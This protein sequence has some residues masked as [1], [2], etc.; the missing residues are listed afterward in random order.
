MFSHC[1]RRIARQAVLIGC[2][3]V[4]AGC[5][6][7]QVPRI[8]PT[9]ESFFIWPNQAP[10]AVVAAPA[11]G[12]PIVGAPTAGA[13]GMP[14]PGPIAPATGIGAP[15]GNLQAPPVY[16]DPTPLAASVTAPTAVAPVVAVPGAPVAAPLVATMRPVG[17]PGMATP[18]GT[19]APQGVRYLRVTPNGILAPI[20]SEVVLKAGVA[21]CDGTLLVNR[22]VEW[23]I[24]G[25]G[26]FSDLGARY[27]VG[28]VAWPWQTPRRIAANH[29]TSTTALS[30]STLFTGTPDPNDDV[31]IYRGEAWVTVTSPCEGTSLVTA[32]APSLENHNR[33]TVPIYWVD[34]Q[35][36]FPASATAELGRPH[37]LTTT[38]LRRSDNA[39]LAGWTVRYDVASGGALGYEGGK[40]V[41]T[42]TDAAGRAS[43]EVSPVDPGGGTTNVSVSIYRPAVGGPG[44]APPLG[45]GRGNA[46][47]TWGAGIPTVP[48]SPP[49]AISTPSPPP[50]VDPN[51]PGA[52]PPFPY[53]PSQPPR[54]NGSPGPI[55]PPP[56]LPNSSPTRPDGY[57]PPAGESSVGR[58][59]LEVDVRLETPAQVAIGE[60]AR[61]L[62]TIVNRGDATARGVKIKDSFPA[63]LRH[64]EK[65]GDTE[66]EYA[67]VG[68]IRP[69]DTKTVPL[70][71][72]VVLEGQQCHTVTVT[73]DG[74]E[75]VSKQGCVAGVKPAFAS[76]QIIGPVSRA[77]GE[78]AEFNIV[79]KNGD[80]PARNVAVILKFDS[81]LELVPS[82]DSRYE[83]LQDGSILLRIGDLVANEQR[84]F[85][86]QPIVTQCKSDNQKACVQGELTVGGAF[87]L[88]H[89]AC[90]DIL[91][92]GPGTL[93]P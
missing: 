87:V 10:A 53:T 78:K 34:A 69:N 76:F 17:C 59:R 33:V 60:Y 57:T 44:G 90:V 21:D 25:A 93:T 18:I 39:P 46:T 66:I 19:C 61:F 88:A 15:L 80:L 43:V 63:G 65:P 14:I 20:G 89:E 83:R 1:I 54:S 9:G 5:A 91:P 26:Q 29:A 70:T 4:V 42:T 56:S 85:K 86:D 79:I 82:A 30:G 13:A 50:G 77:V 7:W 67:G 2:A 72:E 84:T 31:P 40:F 68:D 62:I 92:A 73:A 11:P 28:F 32:C 8:D 55:G 36:L 71:F 38:V 3:A 51:A 58:A 6:S 37:V 74:A 24:A 41:E 75:A 64:P 52:P 16:S 45:L 81:A 23:G 48:T 12:T 22:S 49:S 27:Q 35:F 47:I